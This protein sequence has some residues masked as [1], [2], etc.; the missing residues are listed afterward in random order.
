[1]G[2][3]TGDREYSDLT[4]AR[5]LVREARPCWRNIVGLYLV[6]VLASPIALLAPVPLK[7][8][9]DSAIG[10]HPLPRVLA[11]MLPASM[12][13][14]RGAALAIAALLVIAVALAAQL[15]DLAS[16]L[17]RAYTGEKLL[18][19]FRARLFR[20]VQRLSL[21]YHDSRGTADS[22]YRIQTDAASIQQIAV[23]G[24]VPALTAAVTFIALL[25]VVVRMDW[26]LALV[27]I[28]VASVH[29]IVGRVYK[30]RLRRRSREVKQLE[31]VAQSLVQETLGAL[32]VVKAFGQEERQERHFVDRASEGMRARLQLSYAE[33]RLAMARRLATAAGTAVMLYVGVTHVQEGALTLGG[34]LLMMSY[35]SQLYRPAAT[36]GKKVAS[37][38]TNLASAERCLA[39]LVENP[40]VAERPDAVPL[41]RARGA[42]SFDAVS[43]GY[44][45]HPVLR[46]VSFDVAPGTRVGIV[47]AT[48]AGKTTLV[49]LLCRFYDPTAGRILLDGIELRDYRLADL[50]DQFAIV[51]QES[52]LFSVS[53]AENIAYARP[54]ASREDLVRAA[55][56]ANA[57]EFITALPEGYDTLVGERGMR[58]SG[59]ERQRIELARAFL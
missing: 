32:R 42:V 12:E 6:S 52:V 48:G 14:S 56:A 27:S 23:D 31:S 55:R 28:A 43:F 15:Q 18:L 51:L 25:V 3:V 21:A 35:L 58:L 47:G 37:F 10:S 49:N 4:L 20:Q 33:G 41:A 30:P 24:A 26:Q 9:V 8:A 38:Q 44:G 57:H 46:G 40:D 34:L 39:L 7:I 50:R 36:L 1:M 2:G 16:T 59:G 29:F 19:G 11:A 13:R 54:G 5:R 22:I 45:E 53:I 17:L